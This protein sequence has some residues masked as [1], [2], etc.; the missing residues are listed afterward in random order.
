MQLSIYASP[1]GKLYFL[2]EQNKLVFVSFDATDLKLW[3]RKH[4]PHAEI[5]ERSLKP[6]QVTDLDTYFLGKPVN[7]NW[8][9]ELY[10]TAF[11]KRV[12]NEILKV[13][14][15]QVTTYKRIGDSLQTKAYQA[16][17]GAVGANPV[18][19]IVP[20]HRVL[21]TNWFGGYGGGL[22]RKRLLLELENVTLAPNLNA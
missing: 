1:L 13:P 20:C 18:S 6:A 14:W 4:F 21:G 3:R 15:G 9:L 10:G 11:Q 22:N 7:W 2:F 5:Q 17:G 16:I 12:W 8:S 19:I